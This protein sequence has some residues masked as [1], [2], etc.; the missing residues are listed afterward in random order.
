MKQFF[1]VLAI[2]FL[3]A[4]ASDGPTVPV[5]PIPPAAP[6]PGNLVL[7]A[8]WPAPFNASEACYGSPFECHVPPGT[9]WGL[10]QQK[11]LDHFFPE[12]NT[13][14][15]S[16]D[17]D[18]GM[19]LINTL[20]LDRTQPVSVEETIQVNSLNCSQSVSYA[21]VVPYGGGRD[22]GDPTGRYRAEYISCFP[23]DQRVQ[24]WVYSPT[25][26]GPI[27]GGPFLVTLGQP[28]KLR[29]DWYP[30]EKVVY[31]LDDR[32]IWVEGSS[33]GHDP[34]DIPHNLY[35][36]MWFGSTTGTV[37]S[38]RAYGTVVQTH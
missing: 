6:P 31:W 17:P 7:N 10:L 37:L 35:P 5:T 16:T 3:A 29:I 34:L 19:A 12:E 22:D 24:V 2:L 27:P 4:C 14:G 30:G 28:H 20:L 11:D 8:S 13:L 9:E 38:F 36:A 1:A 32:I 25:W 33:F 18:G 21:G 15:F 23:G 26:A